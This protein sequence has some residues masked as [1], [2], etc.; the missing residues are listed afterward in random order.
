MRIGDHIQYVALRIF[1]NAFVVG[2]TTSHVIT[3]RDEIYSMF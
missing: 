1:I 3:K 2:N